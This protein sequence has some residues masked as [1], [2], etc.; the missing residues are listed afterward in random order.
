[1]KD[2]LVKGFI[3]P[4]ISP[5]GALVLFIKKKDSS[6]CMCIDYRQLNKVTIKNK[7]P[8]PR[9]D[10]LCDQLQGAIDFSKIY[11]RLGYHQLRVKNSDIPKRTF[12]TRY[13]DYEFVVLSFRLTNAP[14]TF[15]D[16]MNI[17]FKQYMDL[18]LIVFIDDI[19]IYFRNEE[20][21]SS[22]LRVVLWTL[23]D[24]QLFAKFSKCEF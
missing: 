9:I 10:D 18:F 8:N 1:M 15:M 17:V 2:L 11:L 6:L 19:L 22:H 7:Y 23:K 21:H 14:V 12:R 24:R 3:R 13:S 4:S 5:W 20:E 16:L